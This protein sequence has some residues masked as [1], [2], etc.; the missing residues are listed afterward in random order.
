MTMSQVTGSIV[1]SENQQLPHGWKTILAHR[2]KDDQTSLCYIS[3]A[4]KRFFSLESARSYIIESF[5]NDIEDNIN[6]D[7][8]KIIHFQRLDNATSNKLVNNNKSSGDCEFKMSPEIKRRRKHM[9]MKNPFKNLLKRTLKKT[10]ARN[11]KTEMVKHIRSLKARKYRNT[12][13]KQIISLR[14]M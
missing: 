7:N 5:D 1:H 10:H 9:S 14:K 8:K 6:T 12:C 2:P 4:G 13:F 3:P 11:L